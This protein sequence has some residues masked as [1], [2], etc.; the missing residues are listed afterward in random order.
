MT[1]IGR[2]HRLSL[3]T[4]PLILAPLITS[5]VLSITGCASV[6]LGPLEKEIAKYGYTLYKPP[7]TNRGP[8]WVFRMIRTFDGKTIPSTLCENLYSDPKT[9]D[10]SLSLPNIHGSTTVSLDLAIDFLEGLIRDPAKAKANLKAV[11]EVTIS[12]GQI[13]DQELSPEFKFT[14][15]GELRPVNERCAAVLRDIKRRGELGNNIFVVQ[16]AVLAHRLWY[17]FKTE[18][19]AAVGLAG[20]YQDLLGFNAGVGISSTGETSL[21]IAER[22]YV[23][24]AAIALIEWLPIG[25]L[26]VS[27]LATVSGRRIT[28]DE[29]KQII[30]D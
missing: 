19:A 18:G 7:R 22:R 28:L 29:M 13:R 9:V 4:H 23:G 5:L 3:F 21:E 2:V 17:E 14:E 11:R 30:G 26:G 24:F 8:G 12:W 27:Q 20:K 10:G 25:E 16:Q 15:K 1:A 6:G